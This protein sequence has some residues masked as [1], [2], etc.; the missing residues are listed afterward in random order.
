MSNLQRFLDLLKALEELVIEYE[1]HHSPIPGLFNAEIPSPD[2]GL[3]FRDTLEHLS[4][5]AQLIAGMVLDGG[6]YEAL[7]IK[8]SFEVKAHLRKVLRKKGWAIKR[9]VYTFDEL[10]EAFGGV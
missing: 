4:D 1:K 10:S 9:I 2:A 5:D 8:N 3:M 6:V 7:P